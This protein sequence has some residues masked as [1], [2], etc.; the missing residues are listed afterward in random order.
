MKHWDFA[1]MTVAAVVP[2]VLY[3]I[4]VVTRHADRNEARAVAIGAY[5][6]YLI[7]QLTL[8][9]L[10]RARESAADHWSCECTG[11]GDALASALVK[12]AYGMGQADA[13]RKNEVAALIA[14]GK[15]G[16]AEA[17]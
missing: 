14:Q 4:F 17:K 15:A 7:S 10:S 16:K 5:V 3:L 13:E 8:L 9:A 1:V 2:M 6:A 11:D 12:V